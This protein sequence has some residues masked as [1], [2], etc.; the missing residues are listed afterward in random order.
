MAERAVPPAGVRASMRTVVDHRGKVSR[1]YVR[2]D[3]H[4]R[5]GDLIAHLEQPEQSADT[6]MAQYGTGLAD[7]DREA[8]RA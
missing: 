4:V 1:L 7:S 2:T 6:R 5:K 8:I 3:S